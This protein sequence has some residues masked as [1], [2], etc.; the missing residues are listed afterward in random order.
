[1][2]GSG[3]KFKVCCAKH[4][5]K[6]IVRNIETGQKMVKMSPELA[7]LMEVQNQS[8][9]EKFGREPG[10]GDPIFFDP[11]KDIPTPMTEEMIKKLTVTDMR[12]AGMSPELIYAYEKTGFVVLKENEHLFTKEDLEVWNDAVRKYRETINRGPSET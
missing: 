8:F 7:R 4:I 6:T 9:I 2:C 10:P 11:T 1:M 3:K 12:N 5:S